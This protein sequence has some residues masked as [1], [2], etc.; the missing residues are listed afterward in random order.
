MSVKVIL[1]DVENSENSMYLFRNLGARL[2]R[3]IG[4]R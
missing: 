1:G 2:D 4:K 3:I